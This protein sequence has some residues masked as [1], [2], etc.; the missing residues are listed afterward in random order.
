MNWEKR[1]FYNS[2]TAIN[3]AILVIM[4]VIFYNVFWHPEVVGH[5]AAR[6]INGFNEIFKK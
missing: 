1:E 2:H 6:I 3:V 4:V 5:I